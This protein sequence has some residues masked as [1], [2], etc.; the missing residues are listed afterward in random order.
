[1]IAWDVVLVIE[2]T[3]NASSGP[4]VAG[5]RDVHT[6]RMAGCQNISR[7]Q[8]RTISNVTASRILFL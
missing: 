1:M 7:T 5:V 2:C 3:M 4:P 6:A 8:P